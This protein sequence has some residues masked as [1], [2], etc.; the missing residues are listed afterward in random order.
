MKIAL[1]LNEDKKF[2]RNLFYM[3]GIDISYIIP[4]YEF[5]N[6]K[7]LNIIDYDHNNKYEIFNKFDIIIFLDNFIFYT[8][9]EFDINLLKP[10]LF[11]LTHGIHLIYNIQ[12]YKKKYNNNIFEKW[13]NIHKHLKINYITC[14][15]YL[16]KNL[17]YEGI[18]SKYIY[19]F[20]SLPQFQEDN[21]LFELNNIELYNNCIIIFICQEEILKYTKKILLKII[22]LIKKYYIN[23]KIYFK[24]KKEYK[25]DRF[26]FLYDFGIDILNENINIF[27]FK[28]SSLI[29]IIE[30]GT[31]FLEC[32]QFN[33]NTIL[34]KLSKSEK[35]Y[36]F[37]PKQNSFKDLF[38]CYDLKKFDICLNIIKNIKYDKYLLQKNIYNL[39]LYHVNNKYINNFNFDFYNFVIEENKKIIKY[40]MSYDLNM[41]QKIK[42]LEIEN[43]QLEEYI[44]NI[45]K[46]IKYDY[47]Q[48]IKHHDKRILKRNQ[49]DILYLKYINQQLENK[50]II[51]NI[52]KEY[53]KLNKLSKKLMLDIKSLYDKNDKNKKIIN[54]NKEI[55]LY[56]KD[57]IKFINNNKINKN[58]KE[59]IIIINDNE[60]IN[61]NSK[62]MIE[63][64]NNYKIN[65]ISNL[66]NEKKKK[67]QI[68]DDI[69]KQKYNKIKKMYDKQK[70]K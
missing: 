46:K 32:L 42:L 7:N 1:F 51:I 59:K 27:N 35:Y 67:L 37:Y 41:E 45:K 50:Q 28:K 3:K 66:L 2:I 31:S 48:E 64:M 8:Y 33:L 12:E 70:N 44:N 20:N 34:L 24:V 57:I 5:L 58:Q 29:I 69:I 55:N 53:I 38:I 26:D 39:N 63:F 14:C 4:R 22:H 17:I 19:K 49:E 30:G 52:F 13:I 65:N 61:L 47:N 15:K 43:N 40:Y 9:K 23:N 18:E 6:D 60:E 54:N 62:H 21:L 16:Y 56:S 25:R 10:K 68:K 11:Y 36:L